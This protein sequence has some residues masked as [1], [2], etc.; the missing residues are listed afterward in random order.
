MTVN[1]LVKGWE[2]P[3]FYRHHIPFEPKAHAS[4]AG[5]GRGETSR[6][7]GGEKA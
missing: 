3:T 7:R 6:I 1:N 2:G 5:P 4:G